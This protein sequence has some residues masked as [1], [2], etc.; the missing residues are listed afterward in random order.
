MWSDRSF[1]DVSEEHTAS[2]MSVNY[3]TIWRVYNL[4]RFF[5]FQRPVSLVGA[6]V[7]PLSSNSCV[8]RRQYKSR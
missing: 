1:A 4:L 8:N 5:L 6:Y 7:D 2:E 3:G